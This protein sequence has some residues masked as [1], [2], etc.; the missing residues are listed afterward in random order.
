MYFIFISLFI[1]KKIKKLTYI[2]ISFLINS[3]KL[4]F[5]TIFKFSFFLSSHLE[6]NI[7]N[8]LT[9]FNSTN[10]RIIIFRK[11]ELICLLIL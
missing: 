4:I 9:V 3:I 2:N 8:A 11:K 5:F 10:I 6:K 7:S 1:E